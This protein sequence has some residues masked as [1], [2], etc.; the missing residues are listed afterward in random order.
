MVMGSL[1]SSCTPTRARFPAAWASSRA[2]T[3]V[4]ARGPTSSIRDRRSPSD[5]VVASAD[6]ASWSSC[7]RASSITPVLS[8]ANRV[9]IVSRVWSSSAVRRSMASVTARRRASCTLT[10]R[11]LIASRWEST[12][13]SKTK[14]RDRSRATRARAR[15]AGT[16]PISRPPRNTWDFRRLRQSYASGLCLNFGHMSGSCPVT[17]VALLRAAIR[18]SF[19]TERTES[20]AEA[21]KPGRAFS[22]Q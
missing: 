12:L 13:Q 2:R 9:R 10:V 7:R 20:T 19:L 17:T 21:R 15:R 1:T 3:V 11:S 14:D 6:G 4:A 16:N 5:N 18:C 8:S 22:F